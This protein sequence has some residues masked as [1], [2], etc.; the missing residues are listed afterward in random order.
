MTEE[1]KESNIIS[2]L[3]VVQCRTMR[4]ASMNGSGELSRCEVEIAA[5]NAGG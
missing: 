4:V 3:I 5:E 1:R 2:I